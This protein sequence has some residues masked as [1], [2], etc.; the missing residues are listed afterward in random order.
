VLPA[1]V[2]EPL[3]LPGQLASPGW[4]ALSALCAALLIWGYVIWWP[5]GTLTYGRRLYLLPSVLFGLAWGACGSL[6]L[7]SVYAI[8]EGFQWP[9]WVTALL[10]V[11][12]VAIYNV[13]YQSGWWDIH[14]SPP[15]NIRAWNNRKVIGAHNPFLIATLAHLV[16]F[17]NVALFVLIYAAALACSAVAMHFPPFWEAD[18]PRVSLDTAIGE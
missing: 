3:I 1:L 17:G 14:V 12:V 2:S 9:A 10:S 15:H 13:N 8:V 7:L 11:L 16:L 5:R 6:L 18:G 4:L